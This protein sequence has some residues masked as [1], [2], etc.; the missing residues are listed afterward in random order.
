MLMMAGPASHPA[1]TLLLQFLMYL[2]R[3]HTRRLAQMGRREELVDI[4]EEAKER[5]DVGDTEVR[6]GG[7]AR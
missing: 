7:M 4:N 6:V 2:S 3:S 5:V 1:S